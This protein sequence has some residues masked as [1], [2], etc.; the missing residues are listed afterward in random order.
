MPKAVSGTTPIGLADRA[1]LHLVC[2]RALTS[3]SDNCLPSSVVVRQGLQPDSSVYDIR[4]G[5]SLFCLFGYL[6]EAHLGH[7]LTAS[8]VLF[9]I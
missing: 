1:L 9:L 8:R 7:E 6:A 4:T 2:R 5:E 3:V